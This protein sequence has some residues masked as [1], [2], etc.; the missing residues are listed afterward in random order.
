M[1]PKLS[2]RFPEVNYL[3]SRATW[4]SR[5]VVFQLA[6]VLFVALSLFYSRRLVVNKPHEG[7]DFEAIMM[8][9]SLVMGILP[10]VDFF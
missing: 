10:R 5:N 4:A 2:P 7:R 6:H 9:H 1:L 8:S 3:R